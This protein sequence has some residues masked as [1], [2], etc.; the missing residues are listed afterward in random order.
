MFFL[1]FALWIL[2][3]GRWTVEIAVI[4]LVVCALLYAFM[5]KFM[6]YSPRKEWNVAKKIPRFVKYTVYLIGEIFKSG[7]ATIR[8]IW[9]PKEV[10]QPQVTSFRTKLKSDA[11]KVLLANSITMTPGTIT[12][13]VRGDEMLVHCLDESLAMTEDSD[14]EKHVAT[15]EEGDVKHD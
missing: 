14:M 13:D 1:L 4:G 3:N 6:E 2:F 5:V 7:W 11:C 12:V 9:S 15:L 8:F 10:I